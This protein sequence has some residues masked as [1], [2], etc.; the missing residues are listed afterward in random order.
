KEAEVQKQIA[1]MEQARKKSEASLKEATDRLK[2]LE[3][4]LASKDESA[5]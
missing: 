4:Q 1:E 2:K 3:Q 5:S